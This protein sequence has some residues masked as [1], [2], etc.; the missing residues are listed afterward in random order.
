MYFRKRNA[1]L[2][3]F[4]VHGEIPE[5]S[6]PGTERP[7]KMCVLDRVALDEALAGLP[8]GYRAI[9]VLCDVVGHFQLSTSQSGE[10]LRTLLRQ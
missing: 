1:R 4:I 2:G 9:F 6:S 5:Q 10:K 7:D 8:A 3:R